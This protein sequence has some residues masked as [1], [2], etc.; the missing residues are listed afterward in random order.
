MSIIKVKGRGAENL[1]RRNLLLNGSTVVDQRVVSNLNAT[2]FICDRWQLTKQSFDELV[3]DCERQNSVSPTD[4]GFK[5][6]IKVEVTTAETALASD[7]LF[8][9]RQKM[10]AQNLQHLKYGTSNAESLTLSFWVRS[11]LVGKYS[12]MFYQ[13]DDARSN[14]QS[15]TI[16]TADTWEYKTITIDGD[17]TGVIDDDVGTGLQVFFTL[18]AGSD[19]TGTPHTGWGAYS[20]TDDFAHSDMV[21]FSAQTGTWYLTGVQLEVGD[22][23]TDFEH[24]SYGE[25][26]SLCQRYYVR[27]DYPVIYQRYGT[28]SCASASNAHSIIHL[29][30]SMRTQPS[31]ETTGTASDYAIYENNGVNSCSSVPT[32]NTTGSTEEVVALQLVSTNNLAGGN[33]AELISNNNA[34]VF[35]AFKS[36]LL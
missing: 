10:E 31:L 5:S 19:Y 6:A 26:L 16:N 25:E 35:I 3:L 32:I 33:A 17:T 29:P 21:D 9:V 36:E 14:L 18:A 23:A 12:V 27:L 28:V 4:E 34:N 15:Y 22:T 11:S 1:G 30:T 2:G 24:R 8:Y 20:P 13:D 7:E